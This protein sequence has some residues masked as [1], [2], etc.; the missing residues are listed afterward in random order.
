MQRMDASVRKQLLDESLTWPAI[1]ALAERFTR[2]YEDAA[3]AATASPEV[4]EMQLPFLSPTGLWLQSYGFSKA[5]LG[6][7]CQVVGR[8]H[9][10][11]L[12]VSCSPGFVRTDMARTYSGDIELKS[13]NEGGETP[14]WLATCN[15]DMLQSG[16]FYQPDRSVVGWVAE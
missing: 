15:R 3:V 13:I 1:H 2:E 10:S 9:P 5:C 7:Y 14:A 8:T 12:S 4:P 16:V 6:A 11:V